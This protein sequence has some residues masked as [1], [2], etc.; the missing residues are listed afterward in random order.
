VIKQA[1]T[2][3]GAGTVL[4]RAHGGHLS[5]GHR[6]TAPWLTLITITKD[7]PAGLTRTMASAAP[8]RAAGAQHLVIDGSAGRERSTREDTNNDGCAIFVRPAQGIT[9]AFNAGL[10][11][12]EGEWVWFLNGG[13]QVDARL[14]PEFLSALLA[15]SR[16]GVIIGGI[17]Y[18]GEGEPRP[19]PPGALQWPSLRPWIP[20]PA[21]LVRRRLFEQ[22][23]GFD[24]RYA[25][26]MDYEWWL[27]AFS[28]GARADVLSIPFAVFAPGGVSQ[29]LEARAQLVGE[30]DDAVRRHQSYLWRTWVAA[31]GRLAR[32]WL[33][34]QFARRLGSAPRRT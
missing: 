14:T 6:M 25:I 31:G 30:R 13:D 29:Q 7:D 20:H 5:G 11:L 12:A 34:A 23:G 18:A 33:S 32:A 8:L 15:S 26:V 21:A 4:A 10:A 28:G 27:K 22:F 9:D 3:L 17:T 1:G 24:E 19:H 16:A 2:S